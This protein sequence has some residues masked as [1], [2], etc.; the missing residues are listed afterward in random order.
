[1]VSEKATPE[2]AASVRR[3]PC[4]TLRRARGGVRSRAGKDATLCSFSTFPG[5]VSHL[6][7]TAGEAAATAPP[8]GLIVTSTSM[9]TNRRAGSG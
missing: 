7:V 8:P 1:M 5:G 4:T 3:P 9:F 2:I 6:P